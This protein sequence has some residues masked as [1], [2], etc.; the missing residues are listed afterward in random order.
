MYYYCV[1]FVEMP[2]FKL[3]VGQGKISI[4]AKSRADHCYGG[5]G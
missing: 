4:F 1:Y 2:H 5:K 3:E